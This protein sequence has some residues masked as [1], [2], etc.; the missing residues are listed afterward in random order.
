[1][2]DKTY[3]QT[4]KAATRQ[5]VY[6]WID[7]FNN[8]LGIVSPLSKHLAEFD[9]LNSMVFF[10]AHEIMKNLGWMHACMLFGAYHSVIRELRYVLESMVQAYYLDYEHPNADMG[11]KLEII[12]EIDKERFSNLVD[13]IEIPEKQKIK[14]LYSDLS[15]YAHSSYEEIGPALEGD[16]ISLL[17][18]V[19]FGFEKTMF[20][21]CVEMTNRVMDVVYRVMFQRFP[22][23]IR[24]IEDPELTMKSFR[25]HECE[26]ALHYV[27]SQDVT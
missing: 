20:K 2:L 7:H 4:K 15:R 12:K 21:R 22:Q 1:L 6:T 13:V 27:A 16:F 5:E 3:K 8:W 24:Q 9:S 14:V 11:C 17:S 26:M 19:S 18:R 23:A 10:R 25:E